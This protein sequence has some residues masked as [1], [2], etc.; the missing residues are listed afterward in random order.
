MD[1]YPEKLE[2][3]FTDIATVI[4]ERSRAIMLWNLLE[5]RA[6]T[7]SELATCADISKQACSNHLSKLLAADL[8]SVE[9]QG[10]HKYYRLANA[11][12]ARTIE[13]MASLLP[14][15][16]EKRIYKEANQVGIK[17][18]R[19]CYDHLAG[20]VGVIIT[21][22]MLSEQIIVQTPNSFM[23]TDYGVQWFQELDI[24]IKQVRQLNRK[25]AYPCLDWSE[26]KYHIG[27]ALGAQLLKQLLKEDWIRK[28]AQPRVV[29]LTAKGKLELKSKLNIEI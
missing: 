15:S 1:N 13:G 4:G 25:F 11:K 10:R 2:K 17:Y 27:G 19:T 18:A 8:I 21:E 23:I 6:Y 22:A 20:K 26:R 16:T 3:Q 7:A 9:K 29:F 5:G 12:V 28:T 24:D 14:I